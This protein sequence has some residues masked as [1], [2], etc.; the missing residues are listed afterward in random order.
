V[1]KVIGERDAE[2]NAADELP[3]VLPFDL[4]SVNSRLFSLALQKQRIRLLQNL[5]DDE[6]EKIDEKFRSHRLAVREETGLKSVLEANHSKPN[7]SFKDY[8]SPLGSKYNNLKNCCGGVPCVMPG[9]S[10]VESDFSLLN[11]VKDPNSQIDSTLQAV[12]FH[13]RNLQIV[14]FLLL[15][16]DMMRM[17][18]IIVIG[19]IDNHNN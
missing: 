4:F 17:M 7:A 13:P 11:W 18:M 12:P 15:W 1:Q 3:V 14:L 9:T 2:N 16:F 19:W 8:W 5:N 10:C 6:V